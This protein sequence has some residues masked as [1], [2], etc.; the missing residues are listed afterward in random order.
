MSTEDEKEILEQKSWESWD[1]MQRNSLCCIWDHKSTLMRFYMIE[2]G[3]FGDNP[4][5]KL[6]FE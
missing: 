3:Q 6:L 2:G 1:K 5:I 4:V